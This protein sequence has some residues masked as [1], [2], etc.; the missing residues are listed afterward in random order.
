MH[1]DVDPPQVQP[2]PGRV[3]LSSLK[4][5]LSTYRNGN[6]ILS[7]PLEQGHF[8][9]GVEKALEE[10]SFV[11]S[12]SFGALR[13]RFDVTRDYQSS[14]GLSFI[15]MLTLTIVPFYRDTE[16]TVKGKLMIDEDVLAK[17]SA[18]A[19]VSSWGGVFLVFGFFV[20]DFGIHG[21]TLQQ[22]TSMVAHELKAKAKNANLPTQ[23][24]ARRRTPPRA[25]SKSKEKAPRESTTSD[26]ASEGLFG[27]EGR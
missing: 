27:D 9:Q 18:T 12:E 26:S 2:V 23:G 17:A 14:M 7:D 15:S 21:K 25:P 22:L 19:T 10:A 8:E 4:T 13:A 24:K 11:L 5:R 1:Y 6:P 16:I 3:F 20:S